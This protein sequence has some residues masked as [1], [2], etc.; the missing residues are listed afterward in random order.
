VDGWTV[1][2]LK[3]LARAAD[4]R[5]V[6]PETNDP[7]VEA[8]LREGSQRHDR[9]LAS[10][11][12]RVV[13]TACALSLLAAGAL[14][15]AFGPGGHAGP[16]VAV[17][18]TVLFAV[19]GQVTFSVGVGSTSPA[20]LV[21]VPMLLLLP[22]GA[23]PLC[24]AAGYVL[25]LAPGLL[26]RRVH[27]DRTV[28]GIA[29]AWFA[30]GPALVLAVAGAPSPVLG[31]WPL[32]V[33]AFA[34][35]V[36]ADLGASAARDWLVS[37][38]SPALSLRVYGLVIAVDA[39][40][41]P[42]G[43]LA[44]LVAVAQPAALLLVVPLGGLIAAFAREREV[45]I[46]H[47]LALSE[48]YRGSALLMGEMLEADDP[49]TGGEHSK[50]V[51]ALALDVGR[52]L[53]LDARE[54]RDLEFGSLLHDI[55]KLKVP[56]EIINKPGKLSP[57]E[58]EVVKRHPVDGQVMLDRIGGVLADVGLTVR[59]HHERW[60]GGG[61]PDGLAGEAIPLNARI[62]TACDAYSAMT[63]TR[64]YRK[65]M[66]Q[67]QALGELRRCAGSQFDPRVIDAVAAVVARAEPVPFAARLA[68]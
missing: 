58:W 35:Q 17:L 65:A 64:S 44:A 55:G 24:V 22:P 46:E 19:A 40:L 13:E 34:A 57:A 8:L 42:V 10:R 60:D 16:L 59:H 26:A 21:V 68:A 11:R 37:G 67:E 15:L 36:A 29:D 43:L 7:L 28:I 54:Q 18:L 9:P 50:G 61:Y 12:E 48:A 2:A 45:R 33:L 31:L 66:P 6:A 27:R 47:A 23:V 53:G 51:V 25:G 62:I 1:W 39:A 49:Y 20:Q 5:D 41:A 30:V 14:L 32:Y 3:A 56:D 63:T 4:P 52:E 38:R